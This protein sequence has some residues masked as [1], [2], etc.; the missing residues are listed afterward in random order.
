MST[1]GFRP[2]LPG[3]AAAQG[4]Q[5]EQKRELPLF[6]LR[7][8]EVLASK[9]AALKPFPY[10]PRAFDARDDELLRE[11]TYAIYD[12]MFRDPA[13]RD[14]YRS[15][16]APLLEH[17][18]VVPAD[19]S[20]P[21]AVRVAEFCSAALDGMKGGFIRRLRKLQNARRYGRATLEPRWKMI[22]SGPWAGMV[23]WDDWI[24]H[25]PHFIDPRRNAQTGEV[26]LHQRQP[27]GSVRVVPA[28]SCIH[29]VWH[30]DLDPLNGESDLRGCYRA[31]WLKDTLHKFMGIHLEAMG[32]GKPVVSWDDT[33]K[34]LTDEQVA[35]AQK[36]LE[37]FQTALAALLLP[38]MKLDILEGNP[39]GD[40]YIKAFEYL[41]Q[42]IQRTIGKPALLSEQPGANGSRALVS[43]QRSQHSAELGEPQNDLEELIPE[44]AFLPLLRANAIPE[45]LCPGFSAAPASQEDRQQK[46][47][48]FVSGVGA[49]IIQVR[50]GDE[51][52]YRSTIGWQSAAD[53]GE[54]VAA[55]SA[56]EPGAAT[57]ALAR[58]L[59]GAPCAKPKRAKQRLFSA[60]PAQD[61][62][63]WVGVQV[64]IEVARDLAL[65]GGEPVESLH[66]TLAYM[67]RRSDLADPRLAQTAMDVLN[68]VA[69]QHAPIPARIQGYGRFAASSTSEGK[70]VI[71][72]SVD[73]PGLVALR[74]SIASALNLAM[75]PPRGD[76]DFTPHIT[77]AYIDPDEPT[78]LNRLAGDGFTI[79]SFVLD[80]FG[81]KFEYALQGSG[82]P[83]LFGRQFARD[84]S[85]LERELDEL[86]AAYT[87]ELSFLWAKALWQ[88]WQDVDGTFLDDGLD[89]DEKIAKLRTLDQVLDVEPF[90]KR[91]IQA[92][93]E[94]LRAGVELGKSQI[95]GRRYQRSG[96]NPAGV[97]D[98]GALEGLLKA[99]SYTTAD[100]MKLQAVQKLRR[101]FEGALA[102]GESYRD[103]TKRLA[104]LFEH[105]AGAKLIAPGPTPTMTF[106]S[107]LVQETTVRTAM[108]D[109]ADKGKVDAYKR[110][111][112][113]VVGI[114]RYEVIELGVGKKSRNHPLS[115]WVNGLKI[116]M[117]H[118]L[119]NEFVG[120]LHY[121]DRGG[122]KP[123]TAR[124]A[125][126]PGFA[127]STEAEIQRAYQKKRE[128]SPDFV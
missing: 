25:L 109:L 6:V 54:P 88:L 66:L 86:A 45:E 24:Y 97:D 103:T 5:L 119:L 75:V 122:T 43:E 81:E 26:E 78:P 74:Q 124:K 73:A 40:H 44:Q 27:D 70:D 41:D 50:D 53:A 67:G 93:R 37:S 39:S 55:A 46:A 69:I 80:A 32:S 79:D 42:E 31:W 23:A 100:G 48:A 3:A 98:L 71:Y 14:A 36:L 116:P 63:L 19:E 101:L 1:I 120:S 104:D 28:S 76:H 12:E 84:D 49:G 18:R 96:V 29:Y 13:V 60:G 17:W 89:R 110:N 33:I 90:A 126:Q 127:W 94:A 30:D 22:T 111:P 99:K 15:C 85:G 56:A 95:E 105:L 9:R 59:Y 8:A 57:A 16:V 62:T 65:P 83:R 128:L 52:E 112:A 114:E 87:Q 7:L 91:L 118:P 61:P 21:R 106:R 108:G 10:M 77:L 102:T 107:P 72:A 51:D 2:Q 38:G 58:Q 82:E 20:D 35:H 68:T 117:D 34:E 121:S 4:R 47:T 92:Q 115:K 125:E 123:I 64:P 113:F 11:K